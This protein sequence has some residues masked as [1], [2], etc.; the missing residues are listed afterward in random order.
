MADSY[1]LTKLDSHSFEHLVNHLA[2][3]VLGPGHTGFG[4][5]SDAGR[6]GYFEGEAPYPSD[7]ER[8]SGRWYIQSK[9]HKP[10][11]TKNPQK[12]LIEQ[13]KEEIAEFE[14][15]DTKRKWPDNWIIATNIDPSGVPKTGA[16]DTA[17][18]LVGEAR[19]EIKDRFHIWGGRKI[20]DYLSLNSEVATYYR[21]FLTPGHILTEVYEQ[22][23][24]DRAD[25]EA[26][27]RYLI[28]NQF[29]EQQH[30]KLEQAGSAAD[31]RPGIHRL[32]ID[33]PFR[34]GSYGLEGMMME[35][36][37]HNSAKE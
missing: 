26:I 18:A 7:T 31:S 29:G 3:R 23:K 32:F 11:L 4:P 34:A 24:D 35:Y 17:K 2:L 13:I 9:F 30:T 1:D 5:G 6:D 12:W 21:H 22:L 8:W 20:L 36:L 19:P 37:V 28:V 14:K 27:L 16:F 15:E 25:V 33:L 10:H